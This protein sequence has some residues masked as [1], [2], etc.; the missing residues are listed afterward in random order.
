M[1]T[2]TATDISE[3]LGKARREAADLR[4]QLDQAEGELAQAVEAKDYSRADELKRRADDLRPH[5]LLAESSVTALQDAA[6]ALDEHHR[7]EHATALEKERQER[8][9]ALRDAAAAAEREAVDEAER[10]LTETKA[11]IAAAAESL[12]AALGAEARAG[13]A[14][15]EGQQAAIDAGWEQPS[16]YVSVPNRVQ[17]HIDTDQLLA[18]ILRRTT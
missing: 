2:M 4:M 17:A 14:R 18:E 6:A 8:F 3:Q 1:A 12:R 7:K 5:V 16:M 15:R 10:F 11:H 9:G 13:L